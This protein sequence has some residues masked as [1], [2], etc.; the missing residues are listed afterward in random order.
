MKLTMNN[1]L[2]TEPKGLNNYIYVYITLCEE[3]KALWN[4][5]S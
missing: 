1:Y 3:K 2:K 5:N 4:K